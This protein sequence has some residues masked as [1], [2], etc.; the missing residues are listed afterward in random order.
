MEKNISILSF[1]LAKLKINSTLTYTLLWN[2]E[3]V[4]KSFC[5]WEC[6]KKQGGGINIF[7]LT[8]NK[9][10]IIIIYGWNYVVVDKKKSNSDF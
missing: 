9:M 3:K 5:L 8:K 6:F 2:K 1:G 10:E 4:L 7:I